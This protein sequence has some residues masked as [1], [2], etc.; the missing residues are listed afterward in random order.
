MGIKKC[1]QGYITTL[2]KSWMAGWIVSP[3]SFSAIPYKRS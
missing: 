3:P 2:G 1:R